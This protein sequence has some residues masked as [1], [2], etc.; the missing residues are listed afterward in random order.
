[1]LKHRKYIVLR[2]NVESLTNPLPVAN[3]IFNLN[4]PH[5]PHHHHPSRYFQ[6]YYCII[7]RLG[8]FRYQHIARIPS[9]ILLLDSQ[10]GGFLKTCEL[11]ETAKNDSICI[12]IMKIMMG[13]ERQKH[14]QKYYVELSRYKVL[15]L[16]SFCVIIRICRKTSTSGVAQARFVMK[17]LTTKCG[18]EGRGVQL[19]SPV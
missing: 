8:V 17:S 4:A 19:Y 7:T 14:P 3:G 15:C 2:R 1:M 18:R 16:C 13:S 9:S 12:I 10:H 5:H 6:T 11:T